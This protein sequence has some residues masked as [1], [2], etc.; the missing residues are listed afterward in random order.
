MKNSD[1]IF[2][3]I[4][5]GEI[6]T[7]AIYEDDDFKVFMDAGPATLGH[8]LVV[9]KDHYKNIFEMP[10][11][12][13]A[14]AIIVA[15]KV[16]TELKDALQADGLNIVQNNGEVAGQTVDHFHIHLIPRYRED[17]QTIGWKPGKLDDNMISKVKESMKKI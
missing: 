11:E 16:G 6:S 4:A 13:L 14:K 10:E 2:C 8:V 1:C 17:G 15:K 7:T 5:N 12:Y 9:P 3:K